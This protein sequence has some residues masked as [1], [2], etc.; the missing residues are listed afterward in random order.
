M[1]ESESCLVSGVRDAE[2]PTRR[3]TRGY[4][5]T[6]MSEDVA[7]A[8]RREFRASVCQETRKS[9]PEGPRHGNA[10]QGA[11]TTTTLCVCMGAPAFVKLQINEIWYHESCVAVRY[12]IMVT[13]PVY[14][15][16]SRQFMSAASHR[17]ARLDNVFAGRRAVQAGMLAGTQI[18]ACIFGK[19]APT[20]ALGRA[21]LGISGG[22]F[23]PRGAIY[24]PRVSPCTPSRGGGGVVRL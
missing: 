3:P 15:A 5:P 11:R 7:C 20:K 16:D 17:T 6:S 12:C 4:A 24:G 10:R 1:R 18:R 19:R 21:R 22:A 23:S 8:R 9:K 14:A 13:A 2:S